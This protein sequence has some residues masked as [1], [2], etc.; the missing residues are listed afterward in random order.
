MATDVLSTEYQ[1]LAHKRTRNRVFLAWKEGDEKRRR[2]TPP[3]KNKTKRESQEKQKPLK[4]KGR[5]DGG[6][7]D[8]LLAP[9]EQNASR[10]HTVTQ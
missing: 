3:P 7:E 5:R 9:Q 2:T 1:H 6:D 4:Q 8:R 10:T